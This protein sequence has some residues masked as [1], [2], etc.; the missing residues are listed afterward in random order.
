MSV[1]DAP[2]AAAERALL[3][4][5][6]EQRGLVT[7]SQAKAVGWSRQRIDGWCR[8]RRLLRM[9][10]G[11][12]AVAG[13]P[14]TWERRVLAAVFAAG[15][16]AVAS[17]STA[18]ALHKIAPWRPDDAQPIEVS[19]PASRCVGVPD[20]VIHRVILPK[21]HVTVVDGIPCTTYERTLVDNA[22]TVSF[23]RLA[24]ALDQGLVGDHVSMDSSRRTLERLRPARGRRKLPLR[25]LLDERAP[26]SDGAESSPEIRVLTAIRTAGLPMPEPQYPVTVGGERFRLDAAYPELRIGLEYQGWDPHRT[27]TAF[28]ADLRRDRILRLAR[29]TVVY[30]TSKSTDAEIAAT[31]RRLR[32]MSTHG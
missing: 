8:R 12:Y 25:T 4:H 19:I 26:E 32:S 3:E 5:A 13:T 7:W 28:D 20:V 14:D 29:W 23:G 2:C 21:D 15:A 27:R 17:H 22:A 24:R 1:T 11:V 18:L 6:A 16:G 31:V 10:R 9:H 30:F